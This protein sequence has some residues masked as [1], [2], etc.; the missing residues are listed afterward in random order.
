[1][2]NTPPYFRSGVS[3]IRLLWQLLQEKVIVIIGARIE[4]RIK[5]PAQIPGTRHHL[6]LCVSLCYSCSD[7]RQYS[8][9]QIE[10]VI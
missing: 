9:R 8:R 7:H 1:M 4:P 6:A 2:A 5:A 10:I 3:K